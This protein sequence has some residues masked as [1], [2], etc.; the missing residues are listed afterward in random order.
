MKRTKFPLCDA[1]VVICH[2]ITSC[3][4]NMAYLEDHLLERGF[5]TCAL[6]FLP[7]DGELTIMEYAEQLDSFVQKEIPSG[8]PL[9]LCAHS[10]GG[11]IAA[12]WL[13]LL[14]GYKRT[15]SFVS[16][17]APHHGT[18]LAVWGALLLPAAYDM[19]PDSELTA[20]LKATRDRLKG[21]PLTTI[22]TETDDIILP[23][24]SSK[25]E[26]AKNHVV[27]VDKH[28]ELMRDKQVHNLIWKALLHS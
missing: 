6:D 23:P 7:P 19:C 17:S 4:E 22:R 28:E 25:L 14:N 20:S 5:H 10:M 15:K 3:K 8:A 11:V 13:Q 21:I 16:I 12:A 1:P 24:S 26:G 9:H 18:S 27:S 2:G